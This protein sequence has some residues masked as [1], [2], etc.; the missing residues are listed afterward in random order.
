[1]VM[2]IGKFSPHMLRMDFPRDLE[3]YHERGRG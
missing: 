1:M 3:R 2:N